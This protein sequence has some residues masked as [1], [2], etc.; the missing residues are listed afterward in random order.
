MTSRGSPISPGGD[1]RRRLVAQRIEADVEAD[2]VHQP[3]PRPRVDQVGGLG[4]VERQGLLADDVLAG[5]ER[6]P[7]LFGVD[8]VGAGDVDDVDLGVGREGLEVS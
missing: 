7:D 3:G 6:G 4:G 2:R 8:V 5:G 1:H